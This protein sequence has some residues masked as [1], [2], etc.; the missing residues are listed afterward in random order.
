M[1]RHR[2]FIG[3]QYFTY[4]KKT[5]ECK[6]VGCGYTYAPK[7]GSDLHSKP[8]IDHLKRRHLEEYNKAIDEAEEKRAR[9]RKLGRVWAHN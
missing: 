4:T 6:H 2:E 5:A 9:K 3:N 8:L 7:S 1:G